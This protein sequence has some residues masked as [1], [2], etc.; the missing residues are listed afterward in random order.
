MGIHGPVPSRMSSTFQRY[1]LP[2]FVFMAVVIGGGYATGREVVQFFFPMG[3]WGGFK[4]Q[5]V[6]ALVWSVVCAISFEL[7]RVT[8]A[9]DYRTFTAALLGRFC[10]GGR[11]GGR[12][13]GWRGGERMFRQVGAV[14][15][16]FIVPTCSSAL[17]LI[18]LPRLA[19]NGQARSLLSGATGWRGGFFGLAR[20]TGGDT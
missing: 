5:A 12:E 16:A 13:P 8:K 3:A 9:Y 17:V 14:K 19:C 6:S 20:P 10:A 1:L 2:G 11:S 15:W 4:G 7:A 18:C